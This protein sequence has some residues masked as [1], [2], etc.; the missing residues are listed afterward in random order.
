MLG[1]GLGLWLRFIKVFGCIASKYWSWYTEKA[2]ILFLEC[3]RIILQATPI[4][5]IRHSCQYFPLSS[6]ISGGPVTPLSS[7]Q[8][9]YVEQA[10][11]FPCFLQ[12]LPCLT[13]VIG[14]ISCS[15][16]LLWNASLVQCGQFSRM[17]RLLYLKADTLCMGNELMICINKWPEH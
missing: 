10:V 8:S 7:V 12:I 6:T 9:S 13:F 5:Y 11:R 1:L 14:Y 16:L 17:H 4:S 3:S 15:D 2:I